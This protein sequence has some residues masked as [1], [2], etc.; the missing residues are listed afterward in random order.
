MIIVTVIVGMMA[1][2]IERTI[3]GVTETE[4]SLRA[5][6]NTVDRGQRALS[7]LRD[8]VATSRKLF[9]H[10]AV[11]DAYLAKLAFGT[12]PLLPARVSRSSTRRTRSVPTSPARR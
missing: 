12:S 10:D 1:L 7:S 8:A 9:Q 3:S 5:I 4:R 11:G 6:R 2:V